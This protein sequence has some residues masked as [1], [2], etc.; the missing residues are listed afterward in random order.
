MLFQKSLI[1]LAIS[2]VLDPKK[3]KY[4]LYIDKDTGNMSEKLK[5]NNEYYKIYTDC[6]DGNIILKKQRKKAQVRFFE[7]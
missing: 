5:Y 1:Y 4:L 3:C 7:D 2:R 6:N